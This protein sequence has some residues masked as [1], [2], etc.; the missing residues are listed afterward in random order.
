MTTKSRDVKVALAH[1]SFLQWGGAERVMRDLCQAFPEAII[2]TL[3]ADKGVKKR[4][5]VIRVVESWLKYVYW[6]FPKF[7]Y[8]LP[9]LPFFVRTLHVE[10]C[11]VLVS[12]SSALIKAIKKPAGSVHI[13]YCH[14]P[15]RFIWSDVEYV[16]QEVP[17]GLR[18]IAKL[19][20][21]WMKKWDFDKAQEPDLLIANCEEVRRRIR[22][23][24]NRDSTVV[25]PGVDTEY[26]KQTI[27]KAGNYLIVARLQA[28]KQVDLVIEAFNELGLELRI[29]GT[30]RIESS[31]RKIARSNIKFLGSVSDVELRNEYSQARAVLYPQYED[32]GLVPLEA[33]SCGTPTLA[34]A[35]GGAL[36]TI[37]PGVT[38]ELFQEQTKSGLLHILKDF[39]PKKYRTEDLRSQALK[40]SK[41]NF[42]ARIKEIVTQE[43]GR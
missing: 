14:T 9:F 3:I 18:S 28:H 17:L 29:V 21:S 8:W 10:E 40:F 5:P 30:G 27:P 2:Y 41:A 22:R 38:G 32:F 42:I 33:A 7:T 16:D 36:E 19:F 6:I 4:F 39:D 12:S 13:N 15:T 37:I 23:Y 26:W 1:D 11:D 43:A 25:Y 31:L 24:Y 35:K 34:Y 20:L